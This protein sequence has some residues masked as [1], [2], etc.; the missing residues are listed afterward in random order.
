MNQTKAQHSA[1]SPLHDISTPHMRAVRKELL[2]LRAEV[3]RSEFVQA[4]HELRAKFSSFGWLKLVVPGF[5]GSRRSGK[6]INA[7]ISEFFGAHPLVSSLASLI[8]A[9]PLR[10][11]VA[12]GAKPLAKW[13]GLGV[14]AWGAYKLA[15]LLSHRGEHADDAGGPPPHG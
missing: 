2:L 11:G 14:A 8:L 10:A 3:E 12:A 6:G 13:G 7:G 4:R 9:R 1:H 5:S 15:T